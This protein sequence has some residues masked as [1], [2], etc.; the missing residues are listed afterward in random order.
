MR[1]E[2]T[3][4]EVYLNTTYK[5][6]PCEERHSWVYIA[7]H[8]LTMWNVSTRC[9]KLELKWSADLI[10]LIGRDNVHIWV[11]V[12]YLNFLVPKRGN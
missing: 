5:V 12:A 3:L 7:L 8:D 6:A 10:V 4:K 2:Q 1:K 11:T 9:G